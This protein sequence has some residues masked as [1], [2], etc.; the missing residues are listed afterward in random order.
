MVNVFCVFSK[1][2]VY[3]P[4][5]FMETT[6]TSIVFLDMR[7]QLFIPQLDEDAQERLIHIQQDG[8]PSHYL[9]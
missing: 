1:E 3:G 5:S 8:A 4:F 2:R 9:E 6:I 7:Q